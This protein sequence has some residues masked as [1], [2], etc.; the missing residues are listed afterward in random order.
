M[1]CSLAED[2]LA[3]NKRNRRLL[4]LFQTTFQQRP[5]MPLEKQQIEIVDQKPRLLEIK[6]EGNAYLMYSFELAMP[7]PG[8]TTLLPAGSSSSIPFS[9]SSTVFGSYS[10]GGGILET[11]NM[12][13]RCRRSCMYDADV[14][15]RLVSGFVNEQHSEIDRD[16]VIKLPRGSDAMSLLTALNLNVWDPAAAK[17]DATRR[18]TGR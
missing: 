11:L 7:S 10:G 15:L 9:S 1:S 8:V 3:A 14:A 16:H 4:N 18:L 2:H 6:K 17:N 5:V 13:D 12:L